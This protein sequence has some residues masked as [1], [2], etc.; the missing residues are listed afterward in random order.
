VDEQPRPYSGSTAVGTSSTGD[1]ASEVKE[2]A[3]TAE[4]KED[5]VSPEE[6]DDKVSPDEKQK[7]VTPEERRSR[8][9]S[10][11]QRL[12]IPVEAFTTALR[13]RARSR[14]RSKSLLP[15][16]KPSEE[17]EK[18][19]PSLPSSHEK[20][21]RLSIDAE[22]AAHQGLGDEKPSPSDIDTEKPRLDLDTVTVTGPAWPLREE[23]DDEKAKR[24]SDRSSVSKRTNS[25]DSLDTPTSPDFAHDEKK[26]LS[27]IT[28]NRA[29]HSK[30]EDEGLDGKTECEDETPEQVRK[31]KMRESRLKLKVIQP[32]DEQD[33]IDMFQCM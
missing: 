25:V 29:R 30:L 32:K 3:V 15:P 26:H 17:D 18:N 2:K 20:P 4:E 10:V 24:L 9:R 33:R 6:K 16:P 22:K 5:K 1:I 7:K 31:R 28:S 21:P 12:A 13:D 27:T 23:N 11:S 19:V 8:S 14:S